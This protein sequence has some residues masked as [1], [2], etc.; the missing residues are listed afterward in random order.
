[1][2]LPLAV[3]VNFALLGKLYSV[4][5]LSNPFFLSIFSAA[6]TLLCVAYS[7]KIGGYS[8]SG[9]VAEYIYGKE[10]TEYNDI[11]KRLAEEIKIL[12]KE[13]NI[14][15][16]EP[17]N[18]IRATVIGAAAFSRKVSG[19]TCYVDKNLKFP[20]KNIPVIKVNLNRKEFSIKKTKKA[21]HQAY[22][23]FDMKEGEDIVALFFEEAIYKSEYYIK[24]FAKALESSF[25][26]SIKNNKLII[27][28]FKEDIGGTVGLTLKKETSL[29]RN[30]MCIDEIELNEGDWI[31]IGEPVYSGQ[32]Y[33]VTVKSLVFSNK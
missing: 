18:T 3:K 5:T 20:I 21:I 17:E 15:L 23:K 14:P 24:E 6:N 1:M 13:N 4:G 16:I 27:L 9:G 25:T 8:F 31:D 32:V 22:S 26:N 11:G 2:G 12:I 19:S 30:F 33:P 28:I 7:M 29:K 10:A